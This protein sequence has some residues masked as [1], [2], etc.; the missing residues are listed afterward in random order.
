MSGMRELVFFYRHLSFN[1]VFT[2]RRRSASSTCGNNEINFGKQ[3]I[4]NSSNPLGGAGGM[5]FELLA[6]LHFV[7]SHFQ[8][9]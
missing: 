7:S 1:R 8:F 9:P 2:F 5:S 4:K 3:K 6:R